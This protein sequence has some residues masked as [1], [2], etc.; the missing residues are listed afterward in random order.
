MPDLIWQNFPYES[1]ISYGSLPFLYVGDRKP[2]V[3]IPSGILSDPELKAA[4][5]KR[6]VQP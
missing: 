3:P 2:F 6:Y 1:G 4:D 5:W